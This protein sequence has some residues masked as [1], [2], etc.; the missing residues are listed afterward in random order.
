MPSYPGTPRELLF[1]E[2][3]SRQLGSKEKSLLWRK[4]KSTQQPTNQQHMLLLNFCVKYTME[5]SITKRRNCDFKCWRRRIRTQQKQ[6]NNLLLRQ[7]KNQ[8]PTMPPLLPPTVQGTA[9]P[10]TTPG[11][12]VQEAERQVPAT[13][14]T[15][16][17]SS[18]TAW[19][20]VTV[21]MVN[22][23]HWYK[24]NC[25]VDTNGKHSSK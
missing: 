11:L 23:W 22:G 2:T 1:L 20:K 7:Q 12:T 25:N 16:G 13:S 21:A 9:I 4:R 10:P 3:N 18:S 14:A 24:G 17:R 15:E 6:S 5:I 19:T 8:Y